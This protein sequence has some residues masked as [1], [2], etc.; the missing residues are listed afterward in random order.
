MAAHGAVL[1][2]SISIPTEQHESRN[3]TPVEQHEL[4]LLHSGYNQE[5]TIEHGDQDE[6][7]A[8]SSPSV[9]PEALTPGATGAASAGQNGPSGPPIELDGEGTQP[10]TAGTTGPPT[11]SA[12]LSSDTCNATASPSPDTTGTSE[13]PE[14]QPSVTGTTPEATTPSPPQEKEEGHWIPWELKPWWF[15]VLLSLQLG[16]IA[17]ICTLSVISSTRSGF[18]PVADVPRFLEP[19]PALAKA[20]WTEGFLWNFFPTLYMAIYGMVWKSVV[21]ASVERQPFVSLNPVLKLAA[22][23]GSPL[24]GQA[25]SG[26]EQNSTELNPAERQ[27]AVIGAK[28]DYAGYNNFR[29]WMVAL[30]RGHIILGISM[31]LALLWSVICI[32]LSA[33]LFTDAEFT[34]NN[35][36][37]VI[38]RV[39]FDGL[40]YSLQRDADLRPIFQTASA[41]KIYDASP[42]T[43]T[44]GE[45]AFAPFYPATSPPEQA[46]LTVTTSGYSGNLD[47]QIIHASDYNVVK[48]GSDFVFTTEDRGCL[49]SWRTSVDSPYKM[50]VKTGSNRTCGPDGYRSRIGFISGIN[51]S[52]SLPQNV[53]FVTCIP[54]YWITQGNLTVV[55]GAS[56]NPNFTVLSDFVPSDLS[57]PFYFLTWNLFETNLLSATS[58]NPMGDLEGNEFAQDIYALANRVNPASPLDSQILMDSMSVLFSTIFAALSSMVLFQPGEPTTLNGTK[59]VL[60]NRLMVNVPIA[61][62]LAG[63]VAVMVAMTMLLF[64][65]STKSSILHK[66]PEGLVGY[67]EL[68]SRPEISEFVN[69]V[70]EGNV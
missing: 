27:E 56:K 67:A 58:F 31:F 22:K 17:A 51:K 33:F 8:T 47:C 69:G 19:H 6:A 2:P 28:L 55:Y 3:Q 7:I 37:A 29:G 11:P 57:N 61:I 16:T 70:R 48:S 52:N 38:S 15:C 54:S 12:V 66:E 18:A 45:F 34:F 43:W 13:S 32:P 64:W 23:P 21:D 39:A 60:R 36:E 5:A 35:T 30:S 25:R 68:L 24:N 4:Q 59:L 65:Q 62:V 9:G 40:A 50:F 42:A 1:R 63:I 49:L 10:G 14:S 41:T 53:S 26:I 46:N 20:L 44:Y